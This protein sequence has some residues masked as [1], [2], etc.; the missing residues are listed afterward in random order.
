MC[1]DEVTLKMKLCVPFL[2]T[3]LTS[4]QFLCH[5][6]AVDY[7]QDYLNQMPKLQSHSSYWQCWMNL[8]ISPWEIWHIEL[9]TIFLKTGFYKLLWSKSWRS[10]KLNGILLFFD[11]GWGGIW[12]Y[13]IRS[14]F[15]W[16]SLCKAIGDQGFFSYN[17]YSSF[18][19]AAV[20]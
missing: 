13:S 10:K 19:I 3:G 15:F 7:F 5:H 11:M 8:L 1:T 18:G 17:R 14:L 20:L 12:C 16:C 9:Q 4:M 6:W 2:W